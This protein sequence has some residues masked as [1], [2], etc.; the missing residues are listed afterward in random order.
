MLISCTRALEV[1]Y[2]DRIC[3]RNPHLCLETRGGANCRALLN[4]TR[5]MIQLSRADRLPLHVAT[6]QCTVR[7]TLSCQLEAQIGEEGP[8]AERILRQVSS[9]CN[10]IY[11]TKGIQGYAT[12]SGLA[13]LPSG[14]LL[15][16]SSWRDGMD[17]RIH[18]RRQSTQVILLYA[19]PM[20]KGATCPYKSLLLTPASVCCFL[21]TLPYHSPRGRQ[22]LNQSCSPPLS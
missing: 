16:K 10:P 15:A 2:G 7:L 18:G 8:E 12:A 11:Y 22:W 9:E 20:M 17:T 1:K 19:P 5:F 13:L 21:I 4:P 3:Y 6:V 14:P